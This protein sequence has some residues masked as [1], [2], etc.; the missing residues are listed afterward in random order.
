MVL[1][2]T[3][4]FDPPAVLAL[5]GGWFMFPFVSK[6]P[7]QARKVIHLQADVS[8]SIIRVTDRDGLEQRYLLHV[9][10]VAW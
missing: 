4:A 7:V 10:W 8:G 2:Q 6:Q 1:G 3:L 9:A 5:Q